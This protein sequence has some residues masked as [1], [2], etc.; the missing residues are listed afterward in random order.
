VSGQPAHILVDMCFLGWPAVEE[1][2][3]TI[4]LP[5]GSRLE[6]LLGLY[7]Q[8]NI[9]DEIWV[10]RIA[11]EGWMVLSADRGKRCGG[12]KLPKLLVQYEIRHILVSGRLHNMRL[13]Q[14]LR[15]IIDLWDRILQAYDS[16][17]GSRFLLQMDRNQCPVLRGPVSVTQK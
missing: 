1:L 17:P 9:L 15:V 10:P 11:Q 16:P 2:R 6:H 8:Q 13:D 12:E 3:R 5:E 7:Q 4:H 14:K